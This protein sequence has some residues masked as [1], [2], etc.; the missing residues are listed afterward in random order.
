ML[1]RIYNS[2]HTLSRH[3]SLPLFMLKEVLKPS[4]L[5]V[6]LPHGDIFFFFP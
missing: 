6:R 3:D 4:K 5:E 2:F 1:K